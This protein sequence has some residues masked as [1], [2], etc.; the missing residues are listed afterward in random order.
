MLICYFVAG[1]AGDAGASGA[2]GA[3]AV[4]FCSVVTPS[5]TE[6]FFDDV[7][8]SPSDVS[9]KTIAAPVVSLDRKL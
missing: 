1:A 4:C 2:S 3:G 5:M 8:A 6:L 9:M 7:I